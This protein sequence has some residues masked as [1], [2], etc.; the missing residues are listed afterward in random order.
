MSAS[1][2]RVTKI[3]KMG[4]VSQNTLA[5]RKVTI[6]L[7]R[8]GIWLY[9]ILLIIEGA[10]R[11]WVLPQLA[12]PLLV[13][14][15]PLV[16]WIIAQAWINEEMPMNWYIVTM[17]ILCVLAMM[18]A[19]S[20]GHGNIEVTLFGAR[21]L[22]LHFPFM[23]V[24][25]RFFNYEDVIKV[26]KSFLWMSLPMVLLI[27]VQFYSPQSAFINRGIGGDAQG[28]G[29]AGAL[30]YF[31][32]P[33]TFSFTS[34]NIQFWSFVEVYVVYFWFNPKL[35]PRYLLI[36]ST[37]AV[38]ASVPLS[39]SR[40]LLF[41]A[42]LTGLFL[43][44]PILRKPGYLF[45]VLGAALGF[46]VLIALLSK[47]SFFSQ[48]LEALTTRVTDA[49]ESEGG[50]INGTI[51]NRL[52]GSLIYSVTDQTQPFFGYGIGMGTNVGAR[53]I[54]GKVGFLIAE[55]EWGRLIGEMGILMGG[56]V[57]FL[58]IHFCFKILQAAYKRIL[59]NDLLPW[60]L[61]SLGVFTV[62]IGQWGQ[63]TSLGFSTLIGGFMLASLR[64]T[65]ISILDF[66]R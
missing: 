46:I 63:P 33:G 49:G 45:K 30:G 15:D 52:F 4:R 27:A 38:I 32:P 58:R 36:A 18:T 9:L 65:R 57:I 1:A 25:G 7:L 8:K 29:F 48:A 54:S 39:I 19:L 16:I 44:V 21:I 55:I 37:V 59:V 66:S 5:R 28:G 10:L 13:I 41:Q 20:I 61:A 6:Q 12:T 56:V 2:Q 50:N 26:G 35:V 62:V 11:K 17:W 23:F 60:I 47:V 14:R 22:L 42:G 3:Y 51:G 40:T 64:R 53:L 34:G 43:L 24:I 31:R